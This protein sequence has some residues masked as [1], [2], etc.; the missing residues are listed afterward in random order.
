MMNGASP[1][2]VKVKAEFPRDTVTAYEDYLIWAT[3][4]KSNHEKCVNKS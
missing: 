1:D 4:L 2:P 3:V